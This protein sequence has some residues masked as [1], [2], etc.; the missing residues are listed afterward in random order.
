MKQD[1]IHRFEERTAKIAIFGLGYVGLPLAVCFAQAGFRVTGIDPDED[2]VTTICRGESYIH[3]IPTEQVH[4]LVNSGQLS[5]TTVLGV[6]RD[7]DAVSCWTK[8]VL[9]YWRRPTCIQQI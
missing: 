2:K 9:G 3:D 5:A 4:R 6:L 1:L 8:W 7:V